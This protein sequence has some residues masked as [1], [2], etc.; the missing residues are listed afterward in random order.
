MKAL[1]SATLDELLR[2]LAHVDR[3]N[4]LK[5]CKDQEVAAGELANASSLALASVS[6]HLKVLRKTGLL[7]QERRGRHLYYRT[8]AALLKKLVRSIVEMERG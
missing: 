3:R 4:F 5:R 1:D 8:N 2:A 7:I 6:E